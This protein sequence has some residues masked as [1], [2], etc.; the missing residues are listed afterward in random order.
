MQITER[1]SQGRFRRQQFGKYLRRGHKG[2]AVVAKI[3]H[4][5]LDPLCLKCTKLLAKLVI[6][7]L[8]LIPV[9]A[10]GEVII[11]H[12]THLFMSGRLVLKC[13]CQKNRIILYH[14]RN[15]LHRMC[16]VIGIMIRNIQHNRFPTQQIRHVSITYIRTIYFMN[17][18]TTPQTFFLSR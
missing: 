18:V 3:Q 16:I 17:P 12:I 13:F 4:K 10:G 6:I 2:T 1:V 7:R 15:Q 8:I 14:G 11:H 9:G 5:L